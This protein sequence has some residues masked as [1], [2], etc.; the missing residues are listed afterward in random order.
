MSTISESIREP[1]QLTWT[2]HEHV[3]TNVN[4]WSP[5]G[6]W[7]VYDTRSRDDRFDGTRIELVDAES[8]EVRIVYEAADGVHC[9]VATFH[10][11]ENKVAFILGPEPGDPEWTYAVSRRRGQI[12]ELSRPGIGRPLD[13][14]NYA[15]PFVP[16]ALRGGS[17]VHVF[18]PDGRRVSFTYE[19]EVLRRLGD[20]TDG[21]HDINQRNVAVAIEKSPVRVARSHPCNHD[22]DYFSFVATK[23]VN[24]PRPGSD[25]ISKAFE[26]GWI[27]GR[28]VHPDGSSPSTSLA[29]LGLVT[30]PDGKQHP[31]V[32][33]VELPN[34]IAIAGA[35]PLEGSEHRRPAPPR[36]TMQRRLTHTAER[37]HPGVATNPRH[38][39]RASPDGSSIA[40]LM[41]DDAGIVQLFTI[42]PAGGTPR[43]VTRHP[44]SIASSFT[45]SPDSRSIAHLMDH[46]VF[47]TSISD[48][49]SI[50]LTAQRD[51]LETPLPHACVFSPTGRHIAFA[52]NVPTGSETYAQIFTVEVPH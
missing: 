8:G 41:R 37:K 20:A 50:R 19:D 40:F 16:G 1:K 5:D 44:T 18:S 49:H 36:G 32:F 33:V 43:Q 25:E 51:A 14:M 21:I 35:T 12:V 30:A 29:F 15:P 39:L 48:G 9:G 38:W 2:A 28:S 6:R 10:P 22:G 3:L 46:S 31:E 47:I 17:H 11:V 52:Q 34:D 26:E 24:C 13:A 23:T 4:A 7:I 42:S 45:W 27:G